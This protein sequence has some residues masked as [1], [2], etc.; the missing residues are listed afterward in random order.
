MKLYELTNEWQLI[1]LHLTDTDGEITPDIQAALDTIEAELPQK[2]D[3]I[4]SLMRHFLTRAAAAR[5]ESERLAKLAQARQNAG[6]RL[7]AYLKTCLERMGQAKVETDRFKVRIQK[8]GQ[9]S[10]KYNGLP[11]MLPTKFQKVRIDVDNAALATAWKTGEAL[12][13]G[14]DVQQGTHLRIS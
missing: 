2:V 1:E 12:P 11:E 8:N 10:V 5:E 4:C 13:P 3:G 14:V 9:P 7:K 6:E